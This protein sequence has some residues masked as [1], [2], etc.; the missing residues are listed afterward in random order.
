MIVLP[1]HSEITKNS[2]IQN[3]LRGASWATL[4]C[5]YVSAIR[6]TIDSC[7]NNNYTHFFYGFLNICICYLIQQ[8]NVIPMKMISALIFGGLFSL[9]CKLIELNFL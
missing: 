2:L 8:V 4:G 9:F 6:L 1:Y 5:I 3:I 7:F